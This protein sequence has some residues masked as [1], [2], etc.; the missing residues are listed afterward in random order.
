MF[1]FL[2]FK[3]LANRSK[4]SKKGFKVKNYKAEIDI[5]V[6]NYKDLFSPYSL[7]DNYFL[8][9]EIVEFI[10]SQTYTVPLNMELILNFY[11]NNPTEKTKEEIKSAI[12]EKYSGEYYKANKDY[13]S[14]LFLCAIMFSV[15]L[16]VLGLSFL[17]R[18]FLNENFTYLDTF[19][20]V[21]TWMFMW[22]A[23]ENFFIERRYL[24]AER[25]KRLKIVNAKMRLYS[26]NPPKDSETPTP[27]TIK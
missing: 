3:K 17:V 5:K 11:V 2:S 15:A 21:T 10:E 18:Y 7:N 22:L 12:K 27:E 26:L 13:K 14:N 16:V 19:F 4:L 24:A 6:K 20:Q 9:D 23:L 1:G 8:N 25:L